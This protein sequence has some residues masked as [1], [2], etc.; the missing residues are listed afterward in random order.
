MKE[1]KTV[2]FFGNGLNRVYDDQIEWGA[3][4][5]SLANEFKVDFDES[6]PFTMEFERLVNQMYESHPMPF[7]EKNNYYDLLKSKISKKVV[8]T[9]HKTKQLYLK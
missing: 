6:I 3:L 2:L 4:L 5:K 8:S 9:D 1:N 7:D